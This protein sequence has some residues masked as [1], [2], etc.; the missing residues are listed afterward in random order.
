M[1]MFTLSAR[2]VA[3]GLIT[4]IGFCLGPDAASAQ[5]R[6]SIEPGTRV[7]L[8][9]PCSAGAPQTGQ[10]FSPECTSVAE[11]VRALGDTLTVTSDGSVARHDLGT[12]RRLEVSRG[13]TSHR[14]AGGVIGLVI[15]AGITY[16]VVNQGGSTAPCDQSA[17][18]DSLRPIECAGLVALGGAAGAGLGV[19][20]G[21]L[22]RSERWEQ[23]PIESLRLSM[24][25]RGRGQVVVR[26]TL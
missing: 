9:V 12:V 16:F 10:R 18:Q 4:W 20:I 22:F 26:L 7:R 13:Y 2:P 6:E 5:G 15:G 17:N 19:V 25:T 14:L 1:T 24:T 11:F 21:G 3:L 23:I 8:T